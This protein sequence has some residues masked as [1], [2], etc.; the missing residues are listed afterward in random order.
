VTETTGFNEVTFP[1]RGNEEFALRGE[2]LPT[3][4]AGGGRSGT[5]PTGA[6]KEDHMA[7]LED[8][9]DSLEKSREIALITTGRISG[10]DTSRP[11][12]FVREGEA[13]YLLAGNGLDSQ[14][15][16]NVLK[17]PA[18]RMEAHGV[19]YEASAHAM[20]KPERC[21]MGR[22][23]ISGQVRR[24]PDRCVVSEARCRRSGRPDLA[25]PPRAGGSASPSP[26]AN[27]C[28]VGQG[29]RRRPSGSRSGRQPAADSA[30]ARPVTTSG[31]A[32]ALVTDDVTI[33]GP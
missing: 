11:V 12:G 19:T 8:F 21:A 18:I 27:R 29:S 25:S 13:L 10:H 2:A 31:K 15:Y 20:E 4:I 23:G 6:L 1:I 5:R 3:S 9:E 16:K 24:R 28:A 14:W 22:R 26:V 32:D 33:R 30:A 17:T 7:T